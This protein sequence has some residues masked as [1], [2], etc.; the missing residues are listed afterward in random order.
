M[1]QFRLADLESFLEN[2]Q[3]KGMYFYRA[4]QQELRH[5]MVLLMHVL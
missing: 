1:V 3:D 2:D 5:N 4:L